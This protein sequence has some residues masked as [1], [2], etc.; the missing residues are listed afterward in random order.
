VLGGAGSGGAPSE[1]PVDDGLLFDPDHILEVEITVAP[2]DWET[3]RLQTR[4][5]SELLDADCQSQPFPSPFSYVH[6]EVVVDGEARSDVGLRKKGFLGSLDENKP[7]LKISVDE[8]VAD[9]ELLG[10]KD[11]TLNNAKQD[12]SYVNQC[13]GYMTFDAAGV[14]ASRCNFAHVTVNGQDLGLYV[15]VEA[16]KK[17]M[18]RRHFA[19]DDGNLYEGTLSDFRE[20]WTNTFEKK[21]NEADVTRPELDAV[22]AA[23]AV[24]D[25]ELLANLEGVLDLDEFMSFWA[26]ETLLQHWD[27]YAG[28]TNNFHV[29]GDPTTGKVVLLPWGIDQLFGAAPSEEP[30]AMLTTSALAHRLYSIPEGRARFAARMTEIL[31]TAWN[32]PNFTAEIDRMVALVKPI[33]TPSERLFQA[34]AVGQLKT[35]IAARRDALLTAL[36][37]PPE[38]LPA[39]RGLVCFREIGTVT[40]TFS[41][42][43]GTTGAPDPFAT[44]T[45]T[46][47]AEVDGAAWSLDAIGGVAGPGEDQASAF[48]SNVVIPV[49]RQ[50]GLLGVLLFGLKPEQVTPGD[51]LVTPGTAPTFLVELDP[52]VEN[53]PARVLAS[54]F[55]TLHFDSAATT[56]GA[57]VTGSYQGTLYASSLLGTQ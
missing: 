1:P 19:S 42:T 35:R 52:N 23:A 20:G 50:D 49:L 7:S 31:D 33:L 38:Q 43:W 46:L 39:L 41:T 5:V 24:S 3:I 12:A 29:Y 9:Q 16:V 27:G 13:L 53:A 44:G 4:Q 18:L 28:N 37:A 6:A 2:T 32:V 26:V 15:H 17:P 22:T 54:M 47:D 36:A 55:G 45:G 56:P 10:T 25:M 51:V 21:T 40:G 57:P 11:F 48:P 14:P 8:F 34:I 30:E